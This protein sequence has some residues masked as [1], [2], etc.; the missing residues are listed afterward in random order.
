MKTVMMSG[1][2][3]E[4]SRNGKS[5]EAVEPSNNDSYL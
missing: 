2:I 5:N 3:Q 1:Y 4:Q